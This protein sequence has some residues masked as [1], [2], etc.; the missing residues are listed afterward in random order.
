[1]PQTDESASDRSPEPGLSGLKPGL[2]NPARP[3]TVDTMRAC[4]QSVRAER[5]APAPGP[6]DVAS[7]K[8]PSDDRLAG[9]PAQ[10]TG[11]LSWQPGWAGDLSLTGDIERKSLGYTS[12][13]YS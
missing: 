7:C 8:A 6:P 4:A 9:R 10:V 2:L 3:L 13:P 12:K 11:W 1:M 5:A